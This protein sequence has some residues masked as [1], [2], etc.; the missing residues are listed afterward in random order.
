MSKRTTW[1][2][3]RADAQRFEAKAA[4]AEAPGG[5]AAAYHVT[6]QTVIVHPER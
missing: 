1:H 2:S 4:P 5:A 3:T 6:D